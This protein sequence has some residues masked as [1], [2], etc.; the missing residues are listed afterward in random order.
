MRDKFPFLKSTAYPL[1]LLEQFGVAVTMD[2]KEDRA[3]TALDSWFGG[4]LITPDGTWTF[5]TE[6]PVS[7][8]ELAEAYLSGDFRYTAYD[9]EIV[10]LKVDNYGGEG[11]VTGNVQVKGR[12]R[13]RDEKGDFQDRDDTGKYSFTYRIL[14]KDGKW[15]VNEWVLEKTNGG[16]ELSKPSRESFLS[17]L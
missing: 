6:A 16:I 3:L 5:N 17:S 4:G 9:W 2:P 8:K 10:S 11:E 12:F 7:N 14:K 1:G 15:R 13:R